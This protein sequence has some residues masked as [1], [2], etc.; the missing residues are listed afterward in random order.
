MR[1]ELQWGTSGKVIVSEGSHLGELLTVLSHFHPSQTTTLFRPKDLIFDT[2]GCGFLRRWLQPDS[3][4]D[5]QKTA[6]ILNKDDIRCGWPAT[7][8]VQTKDQYGDVVHVPN[9]K[10]RQRNLD[11]SKVFFIIGT[12]S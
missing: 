9:M 12:I 5:P 10:V 8:V 4:A 1:P 11:S 3:Y 6:L 7:V 2:H